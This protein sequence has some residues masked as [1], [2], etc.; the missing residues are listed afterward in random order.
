MFETGRW[1]TPRVNR[2][3][4]VTVR[5]NAYSVPVRFIGRQLRVLLHA[6]DLVVYDGRTEVARHER[7]SGRGGSRLVL[8]H[9]LEALLRKPGAF[10]GSTPLE[11]ARSAG[12]FTPVHDR[13]W[14]AARAAHGL[15]AGTRALIEVLLLARHMEHEHVVAG[16]AAAHRAGALAADAVALEARKVAEGDTGEA[17]APARSARQP[18]G[19]TTTVTFLSDW[20]LSHLPPDNRPL[21]SVAHYDQLLD[22]HGRTVGREKEGS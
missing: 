21:P 1:F 19:P 7:L 9:Y 13:W 8:D 17:P 12:R 10:P 2:F 5:S 11:Q 3:G 14:A 15:A 6:N 4:Q 20:K 22:R 16:L 18:G